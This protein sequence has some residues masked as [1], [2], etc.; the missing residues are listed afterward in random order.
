MKPLAGF[1]GA[2]SLRG[3]L[4]MALLLLSLLPLFGSNALGYLRSRLIIED[5]VAGYLDGLATVQANHVQDRLG[6]RRL[7]LDAIAKGNRFLEAALGAGVA[8]GVSA[9]T[10]VAGPEAVRDYLTRQVEESGQF[11]TMALLDLDRRVVAATGEILRQGQ[12]RITGT[13][14]LAIL[15]PPDPHAPPVLRFETTVQDAYGRAAGYLEATVPLDQGNEFLEIP[16]HI[17]GSIESFILDRQGRPVF[18]SHA[19]GHTDYGVP[20]ASPLVG[21]PGQS[22]AIYA[23]RE[24]VQVLASS[25]PLAAYGWL[26]L[27]EIP[28]SDA[29]GELQGL[30][31]LSVA[32]GTVIALLV[33]VIAVVLA[34]R[35]VAP[36]RRLVAATRSL[37]GGDLDVRV[38]AEGGDE[39]AELG[40]A[41][42]QMADELSASQRR[43][44]RLH[45]REIERAGQLATVGELASGVAHEIKNPVVGISN[46]L[47]LVLRRVRDP[48]L[49]PITEEIRRQLE[50]IHAAVN[51][52]LT[53]ARP[54]D[55]RF[56]PVSVVE[57]VRRAVT[58]VEPEAGRRGV[59]I[60]VR[61]D[62]DIPVIRGD[63]EFLQQGLVNLL[64]NA[65]DFSPRG[66]A[67]SVTIRRC[68]GE[69]QLRVQDEGPGMDAG[70]LER[71]F[72]P[73]FTTRAS[74]TGLGLPITQGIAQRHGGRLEVESKPGE[75]STFTLVLPEEGAPVEDE[76]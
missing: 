10:R 33:V 18:I 38:P 51:D 12:W 62:P 15:R 61:K 2:A 32:L 34:R 24:G 71:I 67:V 48:D 56:A 11:A 59:E 54:R 69:I 35:I 47:D 25:A 23:D 66:G 46:G 44:E 36:V 22:H 72:R 50:R 40:S 13:N 9:M 5:L 55:P 39:I 76:S 49:R 31:R 65:M 3:R 60:K 41:F 75:G 17:A 16:E 58:L 30:G 37:G 68:T 1:K 21:N 28:V 45:R 42:N 63:G 19:H 20:L 52:L 4:L 53:F 7:Y 74:G 64:V 43:V 8:P 14:G 27:T 29:F 57:V 73:F 70:T 6:Q 26:F